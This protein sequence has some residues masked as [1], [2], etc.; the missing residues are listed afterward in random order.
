MKHSHADKQLVYGIQPMFEAIAAN[1]EFERI[2]IVKE[3]K[4][5]QLNELNKLIREKRLPVHHVPIHK[6]NK[7]TRGNHQGIV[8][9]LSVIPNVSINE[10]VTRTFEN[11]EDPKIL[12]LDGITDVR[13][14]G[15]LSRSALAF[16]FH[17]IVAPHKGSALIHQDAVKASAGALMKIPVARVFSLYHTLEEMKNMGIQI[18]GITEKGQKNIDQVEKSGPM[19]LV[20]GNEETGIDYRNLEMCDQSCFIQI[21]PQIDSLNVSVAGAIA[22]YEMSK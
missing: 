1:K 7:L 19:A 18:V 6:L 10:I 16:G 3:Q 15:A 22:M 17:A 2:Y 20:L 5:D 21:S 8:A 9:F 13:N 14:F 4:N 12:V 11:G